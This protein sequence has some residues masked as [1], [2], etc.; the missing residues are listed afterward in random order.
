MVANTTL[1]FGLAQGTLI[2]DI[3]CTG[4][5]ISVFGI[6]ILENNSTSLTSLNTDG[7]INKPEIASQV[8]TNLAAE[9]AEISHAKAVIAN[10]LRINKTTGEWTVY[11]SDGETPL[12]TG[13][14]ADDGT[15][16]D[17]VPS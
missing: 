15:F 9:L 1:N 2:L 16:Q 4:G 6:G 14:I 10:R 3:S 13:T 17:R 5:D 8:R 7:L 11:A 12:Y